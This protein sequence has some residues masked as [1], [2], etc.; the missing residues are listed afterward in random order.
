[1]VVCEKAPPKLR[2]D[3]FDHFTGRVDAEQWM[4]VWFLICTC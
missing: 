3:L 1:M 2:D 4:L